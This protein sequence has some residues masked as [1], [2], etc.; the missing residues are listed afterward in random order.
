MAKQP[1]DFRTPDLFDEH[2]RQETFLELSAE[3]LDL[4]GKGHPGGYVSVSQNGVLPG[5]ERVRRFRQRRKLFP[6]VAN[7]A[8]ELC[9]RKHSGECRG[10]K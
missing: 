8:C 6:V 5:A 1:E 7:G 3:Y 4:L 10:R 9:G 2:K